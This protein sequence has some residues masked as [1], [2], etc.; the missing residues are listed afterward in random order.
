M[1]LIKW[2]AFVTDGRGK[3]GGQVL[4][5]GR[6]GAVIR[7]KV[8]PT[9]PNTAR[10]SA[11]RSLL[12]QFSQ[13]WKTL[14]QGERDAWN[15]AVSSFTKTNVFGDTVSPS[16]K[17]LFTKLNINLSLINQ[18]PITSPPLPV[19]MVSPSISNF[20]GSVSVGELEFDFA[21]ESADQTMFISASPAVSPGIN[22]LPALK[23]K[24]NIGAMT[25]AGSISIYNSYNAVYGTPPVGVKIFLSVIAI[26]KTTGQATTKEVLSVVTD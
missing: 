22:N 18:T 11:A 12:S 20:A 17:N 2:G 25:T 21:G 15:A 8:T 7:N 24:V 26:N 3:V 6:S 19:E 10:Q 5:K 9:N 23:R 1:A 16:G 14:T 4:T 13:Q